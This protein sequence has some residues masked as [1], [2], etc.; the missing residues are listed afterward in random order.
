MAAMVPRGC[1]TIT[2]ARYRTATNFPPTAQRGPTNR[3]PTVLPTSHRPTAPTMT[4]QHPTRRAT[5]LPLTHRYTVIQTEHYANMSPEHCTL[6]WKPRF[7]PCSCWSPQGVGS[8]TRGLTRI[9]SGVSTTTAH[10]NHSPRRVALLTIDGAGPT[11]TV[12]RTVSTKRHRFNRGCIRR[13]M[14]GVHRFRRLNMAK[15]R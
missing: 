8:V 11:D 5:R 3:F 7:L 1:L 14:S 6:R 12:T 10:Y 9:Q 13:K 4:L 2:Q 15:L